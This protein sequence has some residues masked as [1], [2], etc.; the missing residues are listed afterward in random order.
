MSEMKKHR[1]MWLLN[2]TSARRFEVPML[3]SIGIDEIFLPK[4]FPQDPSFRSASVDFSEDEKLNIPKEDLKILNET[5]WYGAPDKK[6][7]EIANK[8]FDVLFF[9]IYK[10][11]QMKSI[12]KNFK[13]AIILRA[14]GIPGG[15]TYSQLINSFGTQKIRYFLS[16]V[17]H[18]F[19]FAGAYRHLDEVEEKF[20]DDRFVYLPIGL[21]QKEISE[22]WTGNDRRLLF[23]CPD[24]GWSENS[25][26]IYKDF[27][28]EFKKFDYVIGGDQCIQVKDTRVLGSLNQELYERKMHE[29]R[30][31]FYHSFDPYHIDS[32]PFEAM[33]FGMP[34]VFMAGG[35]LD[36][37]GGKKSPGRCKT[38]WGA[39]HKIRR[40]LSG[41]S[42][43][44]NA[45]K[46]AQKKIL[47]ALLPEK[48]IKDWQSELHMI[49]SSLSRLSHSM[50]REDADKRPSIAVILPLSY[51]GGSFRGVKLLANAIYKGSVQAGNEAR[52][53]LGHLDDKKIYPDHEFDDLD[54]H[55]IRRVYRWQDLDRETARRAMTYAGV[56][57]S[58]ENL[59]Y[60]A[61][62][63][64]MQY[65]ADCDL[66]IIVSDRIVSQ[67]Q[68]SLPYSVI[69]YDYIQ[70]YI[71]EA[72]K[73]ESIS[74]TINIAQNAEHIF[75]TTDFT[76]DDALQYA[77]LLPEK[78]T[79]LP[80]LAP[81]FHLND[82]T[83][84][85]RKTNYFMW[86]TNL[87]L[88]KNHENSFE[89]LKIYYED[90]NGKLECFIT[91]VG[92]DNMMK[93]KN[94]RFNFLQ[95]M[96]KRNKTLKKK[97]KFLGELSDKS[98]QRHLFS[99]KFLW[100]SAYIDNGTFSVVEA[101]SLGVPS[102]SSDYPPM[103]EI[104]NQFKLNLTWMD[105]YNPIDMAE[106]LKEMESRHEEKSSMLPSAEF[107]E[108]QSD[109]NLAL[110]YWNAVEKC[111]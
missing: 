55:I 39:R 77:G 100:H 42:G 8:H 25:K 31:M 6:V 103:R 15:A 41:D 24:I 4:S 34:I 60:Q 105:A 54:K 101:A 89:A 51:R 29:M 72:V 53:I 65:F 21:Q 64:G 20:L 106:K 109:D 88:H 93:K 91:G 38:L 73:I 18:R 69:I 40:I 90:L 7:W 63:D 10:P 81:I 19:W 111:I 35:L 75:V 11:E 95:E 92:V 50:D 66:R 71:P 78:I 37:L 107:L 49:I 76:R 68:P 74:T 82:T 33:K 80:M 61:P 79:K 52:V 57:V 70:R 84:D 16:K 44:I 56:D 27:K 96:F 9:V 48:C 102:L 97:I 22:N 85:I 62:N 3:K 67:V 36:K 23:M 5:D 43:L 104:N 86:T 1:V 83:S 94:K 28:K 47:S 26:N 46:Q 98:Y 108:S 58:L 17:E 32:H 87:N 99:S 110:S 59:E 13:G 12:L 45:I 14:Y 2:H 30:V